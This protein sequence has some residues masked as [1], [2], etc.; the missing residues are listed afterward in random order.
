M[1]TGGVLPCLLFADIGAGEVDSG[2]SPVHAG[3]CNVER[4][5]TCVT[6]GARVMYCS[7]RLSSGGVSRWIICGFRRRSA[8]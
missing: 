1:V 2:T 4:S 5:T 3:Q 8:I 6:A 7:Q